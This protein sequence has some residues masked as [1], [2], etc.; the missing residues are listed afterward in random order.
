MTTTISELS[1]QRRLDKYHIMLRT[2]PIFEMIDKLLVKLEANE[3][4]NMADRI[5]EWLEQNTD[6]AFKSFYKYKV[7][8]ECIACQQKIEQIMD[9][10]NSYY[11]DLHH[12][13]EAEVEGASENK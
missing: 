4:D 6:N 12:F 1:L 11:T 9:K 3:I 7:F 10:L 5:D 2:T 13:Q 8:D